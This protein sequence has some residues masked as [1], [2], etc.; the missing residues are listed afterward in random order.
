MKIII[1]STKAHVF[2]VSSPDLPISSLKTQL[3][4]IIEIPSDFQFITFRGVPLSDDNLI[5]DYNI[6]HGS[7]IF[8]SGRIL[9]GSKLGKLKSLKRKFLDD[10]EDF[11]KFEKS[12]VTNVGD[13]IRSVTKASE[14]LPK[15]Y[16]KT[17]IEKF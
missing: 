10:I 14:L 5:S 6:Q 13:A 15:E 16:E 8:V 2:Q 9:G 17:G 7:Q 4:S 12:K 3:E 11:A 1:Q